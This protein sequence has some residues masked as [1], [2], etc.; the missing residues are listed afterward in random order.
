MLVMTRNAPYT[1]HSKSHICSPH[2]NHINKNQYLNRA[3]SDHIESSVTEIWNLIAIQQTTARYIRL[4]WLKIWICMQNN[5]W[6]TT[7]YTRTLWRRTWTVTDIE[8]TLFSPQKKIYREYLSRIYHSHSLGVHH[9]LFA[10][11]PSHMYMTVDFQIVLQ[12]HKDRPQY[13]KIAYIT[14]IIGSL[15]LMKGDT[16]LKRC[17]CIQT[18]II[19]KSGKIPIYHFIR[20]N[21]QNK[22]FSMSEFDA[23]AM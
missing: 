5:R 21:N 18:D 10:H 17:I 22:I 6:I 14:H 8:S 19:S 11:N 23:F 9:H 2:W 15:N 3:A 16:I 4:K 20:D 7:W 13:C 1:P 12:F